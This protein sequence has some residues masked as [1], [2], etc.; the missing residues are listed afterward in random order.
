LDKQ[1]K[2]QLKSQPKDVLVIDASGL[3]VGRLATQVAREALHGKTIRV[4]NCENAVM[5]GRKRFIV[6]EWTRRFIQGVPKKGPYI[7]R[8]PDRIVRRI[9]RGMLP[10]HNPRGREA[11]ARV[12]CYIGVPTELK[13]K[14]TVTFEQ[15]QAIKLPYNKYLTIGDL[16]KEIG[17]KWL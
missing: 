11:Y 4:I 5:S 6:E 9:I 17:G 10:H 2:Q 1:T 15:A 14:K 16:C 8:Y 13:E 7:H 12:L 3:L